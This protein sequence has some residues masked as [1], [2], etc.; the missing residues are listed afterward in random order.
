MRPTSL[1]HGL[2]TAFFRRQHVPTLY[3]PRFSTSHQFWGQW[4]SERW[5]ARASKRQ[6]GPLE[7]PDRLIFEALLMEGFGLASLKQWFAQ[8]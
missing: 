1:T 3:E 4:G 7:G 6:K 8:V 2:V 5:L